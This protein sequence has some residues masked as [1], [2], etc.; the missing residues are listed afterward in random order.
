MRLTTSLFLIAGFLAAGNVS[1]ALAQ[2][3]STTADLRGTVTDPS[4]SIV[5]RSRVVLTDT[6]KGIARTATTDATGNY[7]FLAVL[8]S[9]YTLKVEAAGFAPTSTSFE[10]TVGEQAIVPVKL[11]LKRFAQGVTVVAG[12]GVVETERTNQSAVI[13]LNQITN[14]PINR[15]DYLDFAVLTPGVTSSQVIVDAS[16]PR[17]A[18]APTSNLSF[19]GSNGRGNYIAVD[20]APTLTSNEAVAVTVPQEAVQEFQVI[21]SSYDAEFGG[22]Y[23]GI[24][25]IVSKSGSNAFH[26]SA[27]GLFRAKPFDAHN[28]FDFSPHGAPFDRQQYG[29]SFGGP[30]RKDKTF[31]LA[32]LEEFH[33]TEANF[34]NLLRGP[35][36]FQMTPSQAALFDYL[37]GTPFAGASAALRSA[38]TTTPE[39]YPRTVKLFTNAT[40][41]FPFDSNQTTFSARL[42]HTFTPRDYGYAR[43]SINDSY[44]QD[45]TAGAL[46]AVSRSHNIE[47]WNGDL[48][49][50]ESHVFSAKALNELKLQFGYVRFDVMPNDLIGPLVNIEGFGYFGRDLYLPSHRL[51]RHYDVLENFSRIVGNHTFKFGGLASADVITSNDELFYGGA[52]DFGSVF[53]LSD[54]VASSPGLGPGFLHNLTAF[55]TANHPSL[56]GSLAAPINSLQAYD[57]NLPELYEGGF[58]PSAGFGTPVQYAAYGQD[59]WQARPNL[60]VN[61]GVRY[62]L[63]SN[64]HFVPFEKDFEPRAGFSWDPFSDGKTAIRGGVGIYNGVVD[65]NIAGVTWGLD[66]SGDPRNINIVLATANSNALGLPTSMTVYQTLLAEDVLGKRLV[67]PADLARFGI[68][69][70]PGEPLEVRFRLGPNYQ[71]PATYQSSFGIERD[72]GRGFSLEADYLFTRGLHLPR[73]RDVNPFKET[74]PNNPFTGQP[75]FI[76]FPTPAETAAGLTSDFRDPLIL[77]DNQYQSTANS[78]YDGFT[79]SVEKRLSAHYSINAHYTLSK[80]IDEQTDFNSDFSAQNPLD[81]RADRALS[82]FDQRHRAVLSGVFESPV[83]GHSRSGKLLENWTFAPILTAESGRPFNLLLG[84]DANNDGRATTDRPGAAGRNT[85][86]G[87]DFFSLDARLARRVPLRESRYLEFTIEAFNLFNRTNFLQVNNVVGIMPLATYTVT[88]E[89]SAAPTQPLGFTSAADPRE[90]QFG[91]RFDF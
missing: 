40:G 61:Y 65:Y 42:D 19:A 6:A 50:S 44:E 28:Y 47:I 33:Q 54:V 39:T 36:E 72:L 21:R 69:P 76:R 34:I 89:R 88:G 67:T 86:R 38:L 73:N 10:L 7:A 78:F 53:P 43:L 5:P 81:V 20:G 58:G 16:D 91:I 70:G 68:T 52:F 29:G 66:G 12:A 25:N 46:I 3:S 14:L 15:R 13:R 23:G 2:A 85:G 26:G 59:T 4:G 80:A 75:T 45:Q 82:D 48:L 60:T 9:T 51:E 64:P 35:G 62:I 57:L 11:K 55:L 83:K 17:V 63:D 71:A 49:L 56:L 30:I 1:R 41:Q 79:V 24:V 27:F 31:F 37:D 90:L 32:A 87:P 22:A 74:G 8:P 84:F 18:Q 77:Q